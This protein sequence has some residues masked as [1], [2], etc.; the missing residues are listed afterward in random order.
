MVLKLNFIVLVWTLGSQLQNYLRQ[1]FL[2]F[3]PLKYTIRRV[4]PNCDAL[5]L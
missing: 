5:I 3:V 2:G 1:V 4:R